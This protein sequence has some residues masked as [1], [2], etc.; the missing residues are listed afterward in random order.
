MYENNCELFWE[1]CIG[2]AVSRFSDL[3]TK[4]WVVHFVNGTQFLIVAAVPAPSPIT[5]ILPVKRI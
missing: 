1:L 3:S 2:K 4:T 5:D